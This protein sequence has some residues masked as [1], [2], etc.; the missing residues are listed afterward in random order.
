MPSLPGET[1]HVWPIFAQTAEGEGAVRGDVPGDDE[2]EEE[3]DDFLSSG[4]G[5]PVS[6]RTTRTITTEGMRTPPL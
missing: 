5:Q 1:S 6:V 4:G 3:E 2:E